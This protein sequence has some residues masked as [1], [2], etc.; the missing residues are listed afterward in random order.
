MNSQ[1]NME[2]KEINTYASSNSSKLNISHLCYT[3]GGGKFLMPYIKEMIPKT[4][5]YQEH[6]WMDKK[7]LYIY[8]CFG[9]DITKKLSWKRLAKLKTI[10]CASRTH[11][12]LLGLLIKT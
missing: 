10:S 6:R 1:E 11:H 12:S 9:N 2:S 7:K 8:V 4:L 3:F 5:L